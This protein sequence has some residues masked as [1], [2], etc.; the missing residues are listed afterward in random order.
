MNEIKSIEDLFKEL[1]PDKIHLTNNEKISYLKSISRNSKI[2]LILEGKE[3]DYKIIF[4]D[5]NN[6]S[7]E[8]R[9]GGSVQKLEIPIT[10]FK[11]PGIYRLEGKNELARWDDLHY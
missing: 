6:I 8:I 3:V 7:V 10:I 1:F 2:D 11:S 4:E 9:K 5:S